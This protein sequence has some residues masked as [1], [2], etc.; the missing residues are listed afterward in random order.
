MRGDFERGTRVSW[1]SQSVE[2]LFANWKLKT[3]S[4]KLVSSG[5]RVEKD[6][7]RVVTEGIYSYEDQT[8]WYFDVLLSR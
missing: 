4:G 1:F 6:G 3:W 2:G 8:S 5:L 7:S